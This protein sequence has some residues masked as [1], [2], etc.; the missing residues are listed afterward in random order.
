[1]GEKCKR[2]IDI[3]RV[4]YLTKSGFK[5]Y[6]VYYADKSSTPENCMLIALKS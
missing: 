4:Q 2:L 6:M 3:G 1:M 5:A